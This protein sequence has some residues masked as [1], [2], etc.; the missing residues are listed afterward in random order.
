[1]F[2]L[3]YDNVSFLV[4]L[5]LFGVLCLLAAGFWLGSL[6][7]FVPGIILVKGA[8]PIIRIQD[9]KKGTD[10]TFH[11][12]LLFVL[13]YIDARPFSFY[14]SKEIELYTLLQTRE[15]GKERRNFS[16]LRHHP[17]DPPPL[18]DCENIQET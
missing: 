8:L 12:Q 16:L 2:R 1:M 10:E 11:G 4:L 5:L 3:I 6:E 17:D 18:F 15:S 9:G 7:R 13:G 14:G